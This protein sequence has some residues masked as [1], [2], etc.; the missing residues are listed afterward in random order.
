M[1]NH[2]NGNWSRGPQHGTALEASSRSKTGLTRGSHRMTRSCCQNFNMALLWYLKRN[3]LVQSPQPDI[4]SIAPT[5]L[6]YGKRT[7]TMKATGTATETG[8]RLMWLRFGYCWPFGRI[9]HTHG[10]ACG[11]MMSCVFVLYTCTWN[12][13]KTWRNHLSL[14]RSGE[15][16][17]ADH[18]I[19]QELST[20]KRTARIYPNAL[21]Y[22]SPV[23][24]L[25][26]IRPCGVQTTPACLCWLFG[27]RQAGDYPTTQSLG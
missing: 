23:T 9:T 11:R 24:S 10:D 12:L 16:G 6:E 19:L 13:C 4:K 8:E 1:T 27:R 22:R 15:F 2:Q 3:L 26:V 18:G 14:N 7:G 5:T 20:G 25:P 21:L 17:S